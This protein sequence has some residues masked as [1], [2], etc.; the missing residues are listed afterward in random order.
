VGTQNKTVIYHDLGVA[1]YQPVWDLQEAVLKH[2]AAV[3]MENRGRP[4]AELPTPNYL[5]FVEHPHVYTLG[6]SGKP[7]HVLLTEAELAEK[8][9]EYFHSNR[10]GDITYHGPGQIVGYPI[11]DL[12]NF[13]PDLH[14]YLRNL[15]EACILT[16]AEYG[17][18]S[19]RIEGLTG[20]WV[21]W[22]GADPRKIMAIGVR[23]SRWI[24][25]HGFAFNIQ[26]DLG[27]FGHIIP[28]GID[29]KGVTSLAA[30][31]GR[32]VDFSEAQLKMKNN[33][34]QVFRYTYAEGELPFSL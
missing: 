34:A 16:L 24:T 4:G 7:E 32:D 27:F 17:I 8:N 21:D 29:D 3:K 12:E 18:A 11:F 25:M 26:T 10:G 19:G 22:E 30:E 15:E 31:L 20:V 6:K 33:L 28:C 2:T 13:K 9:I 14:D 1:R 5:I 23:S